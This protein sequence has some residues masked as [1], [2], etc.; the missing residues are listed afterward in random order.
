M[1]GAAAHVGQTHVPTLL[2]GAGAIAALVLLKRWNKRFPGALTVVV[3]GASLSALL[4]L[5]AGGMSVVGYVPPGLPTPTLT[6]PPL[7]DVLTLLPMA[8]AIA[9]VAFTEAIGVG[10][11]F[12]QKNGYR[13]DANREL[14]AI[15]AANLAAFAFGG[16]PVTG[17]LSRTA[18]NAQAGARTRFA[19]LITALAIAVGLLLLTPL[20][21]PLPNAILAAIVALFATSKRLCVQH[22]VP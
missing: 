11:I 17:G 15:G 19:G 9:L 16:Y 12:A 1:V 22:R 3:I 14:I 18:V 10:E 8:L 13:L 7:H 5:S 6:L 4:S 2:L 21:A 20:F